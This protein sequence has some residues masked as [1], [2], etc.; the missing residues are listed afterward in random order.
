MQIEENDEMSQQS[1]GHTIGAEFNPNRNTVDSERTLAENNVRTVDRV[2]YETQ[3][4]IL[5]S[6]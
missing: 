6:F 1:Q 2:K 4:P 5:S 3:G